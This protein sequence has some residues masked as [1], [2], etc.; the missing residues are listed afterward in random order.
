MPRSFKVIAILAAFIMTC[1]VGVSIAAPTIEEQINDKTKQ[2]EALRA[3]IKQYEQSLNQTSSKAKSLQNELN[4]LTT[5]KRK[6][7]TELKLTEANLSKTSANIKTLAGQIVETESKIGESRR[8]LGAALRD[9]A[10]EGDTSTVEAL[11][12]GNSISEVSDY[13]I[14]SERLSNTLQIIVSDLEESE[15]KL[16]SQ[17][18]SAEIKKTELAKLKTNLAGQKKAVTDT[19]NLK[20]KLLSDTKGEEATYQRILA[21]KKALQAQFE[22]ELFDY[23]SSLGIVVDASGFPSARHSILSWPL[24][25]VLITQNFGVTSFSSRLYKSGTHNGV[26]FKASD[27]TTVYAALGGTVRATGNTDV[28]KNCY[29]YGKWVLIDHPNGLSTLYAHLSSISVSPGQNVGTGDI[30]AYSGRTGYVTGP[31][32]HLSLLVRASTQVMVYPAEKTVSCRGVSIP[33]AP[34]EA[35]LDPLAYLPSK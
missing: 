13:I 5:S 2:I 34:P 23:Q 30:I 10:I 18:S 21:E 11:L 1:E 4:A 12:S 7:E 28:K 14:A 22:K 19:A 31:H 8:Y 27:G 20:D 6:L 3:E 9:M 33:I 26:D 32:L 35:F 25:S 17:K 24:Q 15:A 16:T 29:S